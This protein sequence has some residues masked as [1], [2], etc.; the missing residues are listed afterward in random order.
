MKFFEEKFSYKNFS[1]KKIFVMKF[2][3]SKNFIQ[4]IFFVGKN[5]SDDSHNEVL[6]NN[7]HQ[8]DPVPKA[9]GSQVIFL[10]GFMTDFLGRP[11]N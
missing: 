3:R 6:T 2:F 7:D 10:R 8:R 5:F 9:V 11:F 4:K 1:Y